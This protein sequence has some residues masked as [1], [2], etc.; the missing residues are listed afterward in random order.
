MVD[1]GKEAEKLVA[2][3]CEK[4]YFK[5]NVF[6]SPKFNSVS[7]DIE[8]GD[9]VIWVRNYLGVFEVMKQSSNSKNFIK[10]VGEKRKQINRD[11]KI[12]RDQKVHMLEEN[13]QTL[14]YNNAYFGNF[15]G[16][17]LLDSDNEL[18]L[19]DFQT[20]QETLKSKF[21]IAILRKSDFLMIINE[22]DA[23]TDLFYYL[24][25]RHAFL[26]K[27]FGKSH[28]IFRNLNCEYERRL[29]ID[30]KAHEYHFSKSLWEGSELP[31]L[32]MLIGEIT[33]EQLE[34]RAERFELSKRIDDLANR[35]RSQH[36][37]SILLMQF[38][39]ELLVLSRVERVKYAQKYTDALKQMEMG[40]RERY[41]T[42]HNQV[43]GCLN[44]FFYFK[45]ASSDEF[46]N[47]VDEYGRLKLIYEIKNNN[48]EFSIFCYGFRKSDIET[49]K[50]YD[51]MYLRVID[52]KEIKEIT[53][54]ELEKADKLF[55][56]INSEQISEFN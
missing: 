16:I 53:D 44:L 56:A 45:G 27:V 51:E 31:D 50:P 43:T 24:D 30:Y 2:E 55:G 38:A 6:H 42:F 12:Y 28:E 36:L 3:L 14:E 15:F 37:D 11:Y 7:G 21:P 26:K 41:Y 52:A 49:G 22:V 23:I 47:I 19:I 8:A 48:F 5:W 54:E 34:N 35:I 29:I 17:I 10:R 20:Y 18:D 39:W 9:V 13:G 25:D 46:R 33:K 4:L 32:E 1:K 40:R